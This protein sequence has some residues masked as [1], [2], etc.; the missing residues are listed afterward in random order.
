[1]RAADSDKFKYLQLSS[2]SEIFDTGPTIRP[3]LLVNKSFYASAQRIHNRHKC[4]IIREESGGGDTQESLQ[5]ISKL[6]HDPLKTEV[7][8]GIRDL[9]ITCELY[10][11]RREVGSGGPGEPVNGSTMISTL[12]R[13]SPLFP[14]FPS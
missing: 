10:W 9:T 14:K 8:R 3:L 7:L 5:F 11:R 6:L 12:N 4:L 13:W 2:T 1:M